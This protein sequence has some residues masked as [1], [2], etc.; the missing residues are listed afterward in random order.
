M[1]EDRE[2]V[3]RPNQVTDLHCPETTNGGM[4]EWRTSYMVTFILKII[5]N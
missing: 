2:A 4:E 3:I 1:V 5:Q